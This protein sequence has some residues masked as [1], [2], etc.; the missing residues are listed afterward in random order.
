MRKIS[1]HLALV[2]LLTASSL[3]AADAVLLVAECPTRDSACE[4]QNL[5]SYRYRD[6]K[7]IARE[8]IL[9]EPVEKVRYDLS[10]NQIVQSRYVITHWGDVVDVDAKKLLHDSDGELLGIDGDRLILRVQKT[11]QPRYFT[12]DLKSGKYE[13]LPQPGPWSF[14]GVLSPDRTKSAETSPGGSAVLLHNRDGGRKRIG[15]GITYEIDPRASGT[16]GPPVFWLDDDRLLTLR[17]NGKPVLLHLDGTIE[18][19]AD[20]NLPVPL[21]V[22]SFDRDADGRI[23]YTCSDKTFLINPEAKSVSPLEWISLGKGFEAE[24]ALHPDY[25]SVIRYKGNEIGRLW[26]LLWNAQATDGYLA[27]EYGPVGS[28][29]GYPQGFKVWSAATGEWTAFDDNWVSPVIGW[30][31][32]P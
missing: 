1:F 17:G 6:G 30:L 11:V 27:L 28:N 2:W 22:P 23:V 12:F 7:M 19:L 21:S 14:R 16:E 25:G 5:V 4:S 26:A 15:S 20:L 32:H 10:G 8:I 29:L 24:S 31:G 13:R 18:P 9:S 3:Q